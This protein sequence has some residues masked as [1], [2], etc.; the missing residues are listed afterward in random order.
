MINRIM[1]PVEGLNAHTLFV[2]FI[3]FLK[4]ILNEKKLKDALHLTQQSCE[5]LDPTE[6]FFAP[7]SERKFAT[8]QRKKKQEGNRKRGKVVC[9]IQFSSQ[10]SNVFFSN[11]I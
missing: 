10:K 4:F 2:F 1:V 5:E 6:F 9:V 11:L 7:S 3:F 8:Q